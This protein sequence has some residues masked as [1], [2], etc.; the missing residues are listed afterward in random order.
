MLNVSTN[1]LYKYLIFY[2]NHQFLIILSYVSTNLLSKYVIFL[3]QSPISNYLKLA[4][5]LI[6]I[7]II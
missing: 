6:Y 2:Y 4:L 1:L 3:L 5:L 7:T